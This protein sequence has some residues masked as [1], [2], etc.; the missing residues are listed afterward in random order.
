M[1]NK[2]LSYTEEENTV[3]ES[4]MDQYF[5]D[6][7]SNNL[8]NSDND[9]LMLDDLVETKIYRKNSLVQQN[10][11]KIVQAKKE[12]FNQK[13]NLLLGKFGEDKGYSSSKNVTSSQQETP[14]NQHYS[15]EKNYINLHKKVV[16]SAIHAVKKSVSEQT[17]NRKHSE[18]DS[19]PSKTSSLK[20]AKSLSNDS[21]ESPIYNKQLPS[22]N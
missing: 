1:F 12:T 22:I 8:R 19:K 14:K 2:V 18:H 17:A 4:E 9:G 3:D 6:G 13:S 16:C 11:E 10:S 21:I 15:L 7:N 5:Y 20:L